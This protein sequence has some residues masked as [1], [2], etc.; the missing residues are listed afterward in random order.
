VCVS[1]PYTAGE[2]FVIQVTAIFLFT[3]AEEQQPVRLA[4]TH[5]TKGSGSIVIPVDE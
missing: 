4:L 5:Q 3:R 2:S 1:R